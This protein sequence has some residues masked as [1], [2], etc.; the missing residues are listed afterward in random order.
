M[1]VPESACRMPRSW[2]WSAIYL[3]LVKRLAWLVGGSGF[4]VIDFSFVMCE[5]QLGLRLGLGLNCLNV[6]LCCNQIKLMI[7]NTL[8]NCR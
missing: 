1:T 8:Y 6:M 4:L 2:V 3:A 5:Y 7:T